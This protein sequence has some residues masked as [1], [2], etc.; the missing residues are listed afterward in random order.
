MS[1]L[2]LFFNLLHPLGIIK[3]FTLW[4]GGGGGG[5]TSAAQTQTQVKDL[6]SWALP[7]AQNTLSQASALTAGTQMPQYTGTVQNPV[8]GQNFA[9]GQMVAGFSPLQQQAQG[10]AG[11]LNTGPGFQQGS[12]MNMQA[13]R[14]AGQAGQMG[15]MAGMSY[16]MNAQNPYAVGS[17]MS[18]YIQNSLNPQLQLIGQ[19]TGIA[20]AN[21]QAAATSAGAFGGSRSALANALTQQS[22]DLAAQQTIGQGYNTAYNNAQNA[23]QQAAS[24]GI[25]GANAGISGAQ[26]QAGA[27]TNLSN[28]QNQNLAAQEGIISQQNTLGQQQQQLGQ[29]AINANYQNYLN[30]MNYPYQQLSYMSNLV[31]GTPMGMDSQSQVFQGPMTT[32]QTIGALGLGAYGLSQ[33][34]KGG[35]AKSYKKGG[36][37]KHYDGSDGSVVT[38]S[39][40]A[41]GM[42]KNGL[43]AWLSMMNSYGAPKAQVDSSGL[44]HGTTN[45]KNMSPAAAEYTDWEAA[46]K[47]SEQNGVAGAYNQL[48]NEFQQS[49]LGYAHGGIL[50]FAGDE[51][52][53][54]PESGQQVQDAGVPQGQASSGNVPM[55]NSFLGQTQTLGNELSNFQP[56]TVS[57][58]QD[59][60]M[61][62]NNI[63]TQQSV[64]GPNTAAQG[65]QAYLNQADAARAGNLQRAS[66]L[67][68]L[69]ALPAMVQPG[70]FLRG[71]AAALGSYGGSMEKAHAAD[72]TMKEHL[73][74]AQF[75]LTDSQRK[76]RMGL[77]KEA[78]GAL[79]AYHKNLQDAD[80]ARLDALYHSGELAARGA[81]AAKPLKAAGAG[82]GANA[83]DFLIGPAT[84]AADIKRQ[85]PEWSDVQVNAEAFKMFQNNKAAGLA[86]AELSSADKENAAVLKA[87]DDAQYMN[88]DYKKAKT[89]AERDAVLDKVE[90]DTRKAW[91][92]TNSGGGAPAQTRLQFDAQGNLVQ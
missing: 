19:Q 32:G 22:G 79:V 28:I 42:A 69:Q 47:A 20:G 21:Q 55:Y 68:A 88:E 80:K 56:T 77:Y 27:G 90:M 18:P 17:Y 13:G 58:E 48:P 10:S 84:Y 31:N 44:A 11:N 30:Q 12:M 14:Q 51:S 92:S 83:K 66:G 62:A 1:A 41:P 81:M 76:E 39:S 65:L 40:S 34:A 23:M 5:S 46:M 59:Q 49:M 75:N 43:E 26:A 74:M 54:D 89:Q 9:P 87:K 70:G 61:L 24:L 6:P 3:Q 15:E 33:L 85:H 29:Q 16:G 35:L 2:K 38:S 52:A 57:P 8:T 64:M 7:Y 73:A 78:Q 37:V 86:G 63:A 50:A 45:S 72:D 4:G 36:A 71:A 82:A 25:Q 67:A 53:N 91:R 60:Q